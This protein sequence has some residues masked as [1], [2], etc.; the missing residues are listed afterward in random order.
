MAGDA[1]HF[2]PDMPRYQDW[3]CFGHLARRG[4]AGYLDCETQWNCD[5]GGP[6]QTR[7]DEVHRQAARVE[8]LT[9]VWGSDPDF[10][11]RYGETYRA[12]LAE[13]RRLKV[14][15]LLA[16]GRTREAREELRRLGHA[17]LTERALARLPGP[18]ARV[19]LAARR[20]LRRRRD[21]SDG[22]PAMA[23]AT[24]A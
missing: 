14:R 20:W 22:V 12:E 24:K 9:R 7:A 8:V 10:L 3:V 13:H 6:R 17:S 1:L 5:H 18:A 4:R 11:A 16:A 23:G 21:P 2:P 15:A 19:L